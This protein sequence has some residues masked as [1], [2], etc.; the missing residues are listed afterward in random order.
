MVDMEY[1][2]TREESLVDLEEHIASAIFDY[3]YPEG[4]ERPDEEVCIDL[5]Q[6]IV[7]DILGLGW[8]MNRQLRNFL[9][10]QSEG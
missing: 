5:G 10:Q 7:R 6:H 2:D 3:N 4:M 9:G 8:Q 1:T